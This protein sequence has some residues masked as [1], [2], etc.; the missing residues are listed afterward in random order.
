MELARHSSAALSMEVYASAEPKRLREAAEAAAEH[1]KATVSA[2]SMQTGCKQKAA[3]AG[4][5]DASPEET[6]A[7][8]GAG[9][10]GDT[11]LEPVTSCL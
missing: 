9:V 2:M 3:V 11:G 8:V 10:V 1:V 4:G 6:G 7:L 5:E